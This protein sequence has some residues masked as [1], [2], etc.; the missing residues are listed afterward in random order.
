MR[1]A[2]EQPLQDGWVLIVD[3][4]N[5]RQ[6]VLIRACGKSRV[7]RG[8]DKLEHRI[9]FMRN[10]RRRRPYAPY[11]ATDTLQLIDQRFALGVARMNDEHACTPK[12]FDETTYTG[13]HAVAAS[14]VSQCPPMGETER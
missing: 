14:S 13:F 1:V 4:G 5:E 6:R 8:L 2:V 9:N 11:I 3:D 7:L 10:R 12:L